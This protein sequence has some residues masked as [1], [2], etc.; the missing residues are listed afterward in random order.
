MGTGTLYSFQKQALGILRENPTC[1]LIC[2]APTGSGKSRIFEEMARSSDTL[3][4]R[5]RPS[6][7]SLILAPLQALVRQ[8]RERLEAVG[9][10][11]VDWFTSNSASTPEAMVI[12][13]ERLQELLTKG[14]FLSSETLL[15]VDECHCIDQWG[16]HFRPS[17]SIIP[18]LV[19]RFDIRRSLWLSA[20]LPYDARTKLK[21]S[22]IPPIFEL[23]S[24]SVP[25]NTEV[26]RM[27]V[28]WA[29]RPEFLRL[30]LET[31]Q[32]PGIVF[33]NT[34]SQAISIARM[35]GAWSRPQSQVS[36]YHAGLCREER[37]GVEKRIRSGDIRRISATSAFGMGM[38]F[39]ALRWVVLWQ[40]PYSI[41]DLAQMI[42]R[43]G[44]NP[45]ILA[46]SFLL[47][48][49]SDFHQLHG[50]IPEGELLALRKV[51]EGSDAPQKSL[52]AF[53]RSVRS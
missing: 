44:R 50:R 42:G 34:R 32:S 39:T 46:R 28:P 51:F 22:L 41:L 16:G 14:L 1:H 23:G 52:Q 19:S 5:P 4:I 6:Q 33:S 35:M 48:D 37:L 47:W 9:V 38:N 21:S 3:N 13:P 45:Q 20:T 2:I 29:R 18:S 27:R 43:A 12:T 17:F 11:V 49:D 7:R 15:V 10:K 8:H 24:F 30:F 31:N 25:S 40:V 53:F 36:P 26:N